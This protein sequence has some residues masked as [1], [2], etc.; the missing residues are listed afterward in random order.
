MISWANRNTVAVSV[1]V[2][3]LSCHS[4]CAFYAGEYAGVGLSCRRSSSLVYRNAFSPSP[5]D[6]IGSLFSTDDTSGLLP[7][8][9]SVPPPETIEEDDFNVFFSLARAFLSSDLGALDNT[10]LD[11]N[12]LWINPY[13][14]NPLGKKDYLI[15]L[16]F[17]DLRKSFPDLDYRA[18][19]F[20]LDP[21]EPYTIRFTSRTVGT[22]RNSLQLRN[23]AIPPNGRVMKC[24]PE[25]I[26]ITF[27]SSGKVTKLCS[28]G[29]VMDRLVG[30]TGGVSGVAGAAAVAG[31][32]VSAF[33]T[34][35]P[36]A[37]IGRFFGRTLKPLSDPETF[38]AP[39][40]ETVMVQLAK[41]VVANDI[42]AEDSDLL[43]EDFVA[44]GPV[45]GPIN[46]ETFLE[47]P[48]RLD[49]TVGFPDLN[50]EYSNWRVDPFDPYR[51]VFF[52][53]WLTFVVFAFF[54]QST[55][56]LD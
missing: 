26:S 46:K 25:T 52:T 9:P 12:F 15:A 32:P 29:F 37:V 21:H 53:V 18:H 31:N 36:L 17:F 10:L 39:F 47:N 42:G 30:N 54:C 11:K 4:I 2:F 34:T 16:N 3:L 33:D 13:D 23:S 41:G 8:P 24:P 43:S 48:R 44:V 49:L 5:L 28:G 1:S 38:L 56:K 7:R 45:T 19:D 6:K 14:I 50:Y 20:R 55:N 22:M 35:P 40:P 27:S 51:C